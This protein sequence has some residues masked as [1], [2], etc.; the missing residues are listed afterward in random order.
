MNKDRI[1]DLA[2]KITNIREDDEIKF[3]SLSEVI[4]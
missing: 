2:L 4:R 3:E 1:K